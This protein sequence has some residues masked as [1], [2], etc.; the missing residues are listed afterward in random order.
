MSLYMYESDS[1]LFTQTYPSQLH[2]APA[3]QNFR[4]LL[5]FNFMCD[6]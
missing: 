1:A 3:N 6:G 5:I 2:T 4:V